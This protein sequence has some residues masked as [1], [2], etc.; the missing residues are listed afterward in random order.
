MRVL[1]SYRMFGKIVNIF[2]DSLQQAQPSIK[3]NKLSKIFL[4]YNSGMYVYFFFE[5]LT[6]TITFV[7]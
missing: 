4:G 1:I 7:L 6:N 5:Q 2:A 3:M